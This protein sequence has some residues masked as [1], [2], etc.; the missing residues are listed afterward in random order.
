MSKAFLDVLHA[1]QPK[2]EYISPAVCEYIFSGS[3]FSSL[4]LDENWN[5][6]P[7]ST[8]TILIFGSGGDHRLTWDPVDGAVCYTIYAADDPGN[9]LGSYHVVEDCWPDTTWDPPPTPP[10]TCPD[11]SNCPPPNQCY[12]IQPITDA[13]LGPMSNPLCVTPPPGCTT[14]NGGGGGGGGSTS[15]TCFT[16]AT[17]QYF[18]L[19]GTVT[20][21]PDLVT[22]QAGTYSIVSGTLPA[23]LSLDAGTGVISGTPTALGDFP[24]L[25]RV[26][27]SNGTGCTQYFVLTVSECIITT[28]PLPDAWLDGPYT[29]DFTPFEVVPG[30]TW[31]VV[32]GALPDGLTLNTATGELSGIPTVQGIFNFEISY[33]ANGETCTKAFTIEVGA[34][35]ITID[36]PLTTGVEGEPYSVTFT[37]ATPEANQDWQVVSGLL[38]A[39]LVLNE[40]TGELSGIPDVGSAGEYAFTIRLTNQDL[41]FCEEIFSMTVL[42]NPIDCISTS[43]LLT[44]GTEQSP[45]LKALT[46]ANPTPGQVWSISNGSLPPGISL[47]ADNGILSGTPTTAGLYT[48]T[49]RITDPDTAYCEKEFE[50]AILQEE[51][52]LCVNGSGIL[53]DGNEGIEYSFQLVASDPEA[54]QVWTVS[55]GSLPAGT[56]LSAATGEISGIPDVG[57]AGFYEFTVRITNQDTTYCERAMQWT[58]VAGGGGGCD[59]EFALPSAAVWTDYVVSP[60]ST[61]TFNGA[62]GSASLE[63]IDESQVAARNCTVC[64]TT[65]S[66]SLLY[67]V[68]WDY[69]ITNE[70]FYFDPFFIPT[71]EIQMYL[72]DVP[73]DS[74]S[75]GPVA[76][77]AS[78]T[79]SV[80]C[81]IPDDQTAHLVR[82]HL[83]WTALPDT[84]PSTT[85]SGPLTG[86]ET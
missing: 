13:G 6:D 7:I 12:I 3:G 32:D 56:V 66:G 86:T 19:N 72:D 17:N 20:F 33:T 70:P 83:L 11:P 10:P 38:P 78:G 84:A 65:G 25:L 18:K 26:T 24:I 80:S 15:I 47:D 75:V 1:R 35:C 4:L 34:A 63:S 49:V 46:N 57:S 69:T 21:T 52:G 58:V 79:L 9:P 45:Y 81:T 41:S 22:P 44:T 30:A 68:T 62:A 16:N 59:G 85:A 48:F 50:L 36:G 2:L 39:G 28:N 74:D 67:T 64:R 23:G 37:P 71:V 42:A 5:L 77:G 40:N 43:A 61:I 76:G 53:T 31:A 27:Y 8:A 60:D 73:V 29:L 82:I 54:N 14:C 55:Q 51:P